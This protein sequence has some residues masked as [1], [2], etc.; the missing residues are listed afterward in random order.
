MNVA[1]QTNDS[2]RIFSITAHIDRPV[3]PELLVGLSAA[4]IRRA[5]HLPTVLARQIRV[6]AAESGVVIDIPLAVT[7]STIDAAELWKWIG[8][9][10]LRAGCSDCEINGLIFDNVDTYD[11][12]ES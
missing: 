12:Y 2:G 10:L 9:P 1:D 4:L 6:R 3:S 8:W 11:D 5:W 7:H